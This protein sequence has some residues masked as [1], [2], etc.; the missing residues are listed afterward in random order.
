M[1]KEMEMVRYIFLFCMY[2]AVLSCSKQEKD[3]DIK[4]IYFDRFS[5]VPPS[6]ILK[7][8][9]IKLETTND[10][11]I[12]YLDQ[13]AFVKN[14]LLILAD[15]KVFIF[16]K[17]GSYIAQINRKGQGPGEYLSLKSFFINEKDNLICLISSSSAKVLFF[18]LDNLQF[19]SE[20]KMPFSSSYAMFLPDGNIIWTNRD[21][22]PKKG[23]DVNNC[24]V[25]TDNNLNIINS[26]VEKQFVSGYTTG[27]QNTIY[28]VGDSIFAYTPFS[29]V[30]YRISHNDVLPAFQLSIYGRQFPPTKFLKDI[31]AHNT[32]Y[33]DKLTTSDYVS[34]FQIEE[35]INDMC[36][37]YIAK[38]QRFVGI[39]DKINHKNYHYTF[40]EFQKDLQTGNIFTY[41]T[42]GKVADYYVIPLL[43]S[44]LKT[45]KEE[46]YLFG[47]TLNSLIDKSQDD[48]NP[49]LFLFK[50]L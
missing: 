27:A 46:G 26:Y 21:Y 40:D 47:E 6:E 39:Y 43:V 30:I 49:I 14:L 36:V 4:T 11:L 31:S 12:G 17:N 18:S 35:N 50:L 48:D 45:K 5:N 16:D 20:V 44:D 9:F 7:Q 37:F 34:H 10:C 13:I 33:F 32:M 29:P 1:I 8:S 22:L 38:G 28:N 23:I 15:D 19:I 3:T 25:K 24:F 2:I 42:H 41:L